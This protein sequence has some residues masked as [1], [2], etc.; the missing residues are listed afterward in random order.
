M[1]GVGSGNRRNSVRRPRS[2][3]TVISFN[4]HKPHEANKRMTLP[5]MRTLRPMTQK[6]GMAGVGVPEDMG[7]VAAAPRCCG[8]W[9]LH[10]FHCITH[11]TRQ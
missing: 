1:T 6:H 3:L 10:F 2:P 5:Q 4:L 11:L 7:D 9:K 8:V